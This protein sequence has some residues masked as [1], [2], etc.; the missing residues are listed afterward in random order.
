MPSYILKCGC[1]RF[2]LMLRKYWVFSPVL[3]L[4]SL[5]FC[6]VVGGGGGGGGVGGVGGGC[7]NGGGLVVVVAVVVVVVCVCARAPARRFLAFF[8]P[9][10]MLRAGTARWT[11]GWR[12][13][14]CTRGIW[15]RW[16]C[17]WTRGAWQRTWLWHTDSGVDYGPSISFLSTVDD[18]FSASTTAGNGRHH[19]TNQIVAQVLGSHAADVTVHLRTAPE[20]NI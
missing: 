16:T 8:L 7:G 15:S 12:T 20:N 1:S 2:F 19:G 6:V 9:V 4:L 13:H 5:L 17:R 10:Y 14:R 3:F 18:D 11:W